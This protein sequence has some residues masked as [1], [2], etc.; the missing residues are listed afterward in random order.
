[1]NE[2]NPKNEKKPITLKNFIIKR[3]LFIIIFAIIAA[4]ITS[5]FII[6]NRPTVNTNSNSEALSQTPT[7][8]IINDNEVPENTGRNH[9]SLIN[10]G[11]DTFN[12]NDL[13]ITKV[14]EKNY[15]DYGGKSISYLQID[16]LK[17]KSIQDKINYHLE[18]DLKQ[19]ISQ[20]KINGYFKD[21]AIA[22]SNC[23]INSFPVSSFANTLSVRYELREIINGGN[24]WSNCIPENYNLT[25]GEQIKFQD[26]FTDDTRGSDIFDKNFYNELIGWHTDTI[27]D[28][29]KESSLKV[30]NYND[31]EEKILELCLKFNTGENIPFYFDEQSIILTD[32]INAKLCT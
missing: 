20:A 27:L 31:I 28:E 19:A 26:M 10:Y 8:E 11:T 17:D 2:E 1:M 29:K 7:N 15:K 12:Y 21:E 24:S 3:I 16:G 30:T 13:K 14:I 6:K 18:N 5:Y 22:K 9:I 25:T 32:F 23:I 4:G